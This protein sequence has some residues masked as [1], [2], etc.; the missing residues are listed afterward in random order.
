[1]LSFGIFTL[2]FSPLSDSFG[3]VKVIN[4]AAFGTAIL[5]MLG[6]FAAGIFTVTMALV[7]QIFDDQQR[8]KALGKVMGLMFLGGATATAIGGALLI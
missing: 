8:H 3:K 2:M 5:S 1:M 7:G 4:I 6:A